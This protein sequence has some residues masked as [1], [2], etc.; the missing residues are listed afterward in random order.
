MTILALVVLGAFLS[1]ASHVLAAR[2][3]QSPG[4]IPRCAGRRANAHARTRM[5]PTIR[6]WRCPKCGETEPF[7]VREVH[8]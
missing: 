7:V 3:T 8:P 2:R 4:V 1:I 5:V 6:H